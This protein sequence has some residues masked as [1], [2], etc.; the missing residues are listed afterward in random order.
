MV[1]V[2]IVENDEDIRNLLI[3]QLRY[4]H[5]RVGGSSDGLAA[6]RRIKRRRSDVLFLDIM[7]PIMNG[8]ELISELAKDSETSNIPIVLVTAVS[9]PDV[10]MKAVRLGVKYRLTKPWETKH[11]DFVLEQTL[12]LMNE[13]DASAPSA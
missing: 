5:H 9:T 7:M 3:E 4:K 8:I 2:L 11:L 12:G 1:D 13:A 10:T 6:L